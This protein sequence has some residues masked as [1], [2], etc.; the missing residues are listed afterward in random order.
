MHI[1]ISTPYGK[2]L[3]KDSYG[4]ELADPELLETINPVHL[5]D[6]STLVLGAD[7]I[8]QS[9]FVWLKD[10]ATPHHT[11]HTDA[12]EAPAAPVE[13]ASTTL[14]NAKPSKLAADYKTAVYESLQTNGSLNAF[15]VQKRFPALTPP[16]IRKIFELLEAEGHCTKAGQ[17]R[18]TR[19]TFT[20]ATA[21][22]TTAH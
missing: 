3:T 4:V 18:G 8:K 2:Y 12:P 6:G 7:L 15:E 11:R 10:K 14:I 21:A 19:Y 20:A 17:K 13:D 9:S 5:E 1:E 22:A 16:A